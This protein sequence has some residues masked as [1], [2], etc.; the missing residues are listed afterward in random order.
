MQKHVHPVD[1]PFLDG[2]IH[3]FGYLSGVQRHLSRS[4]VPIAANFHLDRCVRRKG[5]IVKRPSNLVLP[6]FA[7]LV[8]THW[9]IGS[10][11]NFQVKNPVATRY[12]RP[13]RFSG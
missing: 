9:W 12:R 10:R 3:S 2:G 8:E 5:K 6:L 4:M 13:L 11:G 1:S 7:P